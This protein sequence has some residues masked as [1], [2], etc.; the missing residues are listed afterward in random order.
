MNTS[1]FQA[2]ISDA[3]FNKYSS[4]YEYVLS[5]DRAS[6]IQQML[7]WVEIGYRNHIY[8]GV[9]EICLNTHPCSSWLT[10]TCLELPI[11][12][13]SG[14][15]L[16]IWRA[17]ELLTEGDR[18]N[19]NKIIP[20]LSFGFWVRL[21][22]SANEENI[23]TAGLHKSFPRKTNRSELH[24]R[25]RRMNLIRNR[26]AHLEPVDTYSLP[27]IATESLSLIHLIAP[28]LEGFMREEFGRIQKNS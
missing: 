24:N 1:D 25:L 3:R 19:P 13:N 6:R 9:Q 11:S 23:W 7:H 16:R 26:I 18:S 5:V 12:L 10:C 28:N 15:T 22:S 21:L 8:K 20:E 27:Q 17:K 4:V 2:L 14:S